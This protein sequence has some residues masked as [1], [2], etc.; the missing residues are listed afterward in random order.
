M[1]QLREMDLK[2]GE[3]ARKLGEEG[4]SRDILVLLLDEQGSPILPDAE[5]VK[6]Q[7]SVSSLTGTSSNELSFTF[8]SP[9]FPWSTA[10]LLTL[11]ANINTFYPVI[12]NVYGSPAFPGTIN[13]RLDPTLTTFSGLYYPSTNELVLRDANTPDVLVHEMIHAFRDDFLLTPGTYEEG[14]TRAAEIEVFSRTGMTHPSDDKHSYTYDVYYAGLDTPAIGAHNGNI[15]MGYIGVLERYQLSGYAWAKALIENSNFLVNFNQQLYPAM[16]ADVSV[17]SN[18]TALI[19]MGAAAQPSIEGKPYQNWYAQQA[20]LDAAPPQGYN[21]HHRINQGTVDYF[22]RDVSGIETMQSGATLQWQEYDNQGALL[23]SGSEATGTNGFVFWIGWPSSYQGR[24]RFV[25]TA[26]SPDGPITDSS[27]RTFGSEAG[28][29]GYL[30]KSNTGTVTFTSLDNVVSPVAVDVVNGAFAADTLGPV[31]GRFR[32]DFTN[33][34]NSFSVYFNKDASPYFLP[35]AFTIQG[36]VTDLAGIA[37]KGVTLTL[38][39]ASTA[40]TVSGPD[41]KFYFPHLEGDQNFTVTPTLSGTA[42]SPA[43]TTITLNEKVSGINFASQKESTATTGTISINGGAAVTTSTAVTLSLSAPKTGSIF[44]SM[45]FSNDNINWGPWRAYA[46]SASYKLTNGDGT[47][48]VYAQFRDA[49]M[50]ISA[51]V[52]D[53]I[54]LQTVTNNRISEDFSSLTA[55]SRFTKLKGGTWSVA[56]GMFKLSKPSTAVTTHNANISVHTTAI[57]N[58]FELSATAKVSGTSSTSNDFSIVFGLKD[59]NNYYYANFSEANDSASNG[60]FKVA[61]GVRTQMADFTSVIKPNTGYTIKIVRLGNEI[62]V[63]RDGTV[64]GA[65][66]DSTYPSGKVGFGSRNDSCQFDNLMVP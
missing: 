55:A 13:I 60:L 17:G 9:A 35:M 26:Q 6:Q 37:L 20:N 24:A 38:S 4:I 19:S 16:S 43:S 49:Q 7:P 21:L 12:K 30:P 61:A 3:E 47:K 62:T 58:D 31:R 36:R 59:A 41:G 66:T 32:A 18:L 42:F 40:T 54:I 46:A 23:L 56:G 28:V 63:S 1:E 15:F 33:G 45:R 50:N 14:M 25:V 53:T 65:A 29:F 51:T 5:K 22:H 57:S 39:G 44:T 2:L 10:D 64:V 8:N 27:M 34:T 48:A 52:S 11:Q